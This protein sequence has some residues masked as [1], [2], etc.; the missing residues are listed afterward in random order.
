MPGFVQDLRFS[1][2]Q[3]I[4]A[5]GFTLAAVGMLALGIGATSAIFSLVEGV[6]LRPLP[7]AD[8]GRLA[9][10]GDHVGNSPGMSVTAREIATYAHASGAFASMGGFRTATYEL[11]GSERAEE[12][13][14][15]RVT[16]SAFSTLGVAPMLGR[17]FTAEEEDANHPLAV[18]SYALWLN[19]Y[20]RDPNVV[21]QTIELDRKTYS[22]IGVMPRGFE[23]PLAEGR[24]GQAQLWVPM[25]PTPEE[26]SEKEAGDWG[27]H[28][29]ARL[30]PGVAIAQAVQDAD[31][32]SQQIMRGFP[33]TMAAIHI[34]GDVKDMREDAVEDAR[35][36]LDTLLVA[37]GI[38]LLIACANVAVLMLV[39]AVRRNREFAVRLA[40][41]ARA[42]AIL[43]QSLIEG[44]LLSLAGGVAGLAMA[45][46]A[47]RIAVR[48]LPETM[49]RID[50]IRMDST[51]AV[52]AVMLALITGAVCSVA[53]AFAALRTNLLEGLKENTRAGGASSHAWIRSSLVVAEIA[54]ALVLITVSGSL[55]RSYQ[56]MLAVDPGFRPDHV[57]V[58][59]YRLPLE[60]YSTDILANTF[61]RSVLD[62]LKSAPGI[63]AAGI[64]SVLPTSGGYGMA[65]YTIEGHEAGWKLQFAPFVA[66]YGDYFHAMGIDLREGRYFTANDRAA[67]PLVAIV[68]ESMARHSWPGESPVGKRMHVG[69]PRKGLPWA[70]VIGVVAD[71]KLGSLED[72]SRD[73]W[74]YP[75]EQPAVL[76]GSD[77]AGQLTSAAGGNIALR[78]A[79]DPEQ[80]VATLRAAVAA[81]DPR[82]ALTDVQTMDEA[83]SS[84]EEPR[85]FNTGLIGGFALGA[86][87]L[88]VMGIYA[89]VAF[90]VSLRAQEIAIRMALGARRER[91]ARLVLVSGGKLALLG[92]ALGVLGSIAVSR[93]VEAFLFDVSPTDPLIYA[94]SAGVMVAMALLASA[95]PAI[96]AASTDPAEALRSI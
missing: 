68:N 55:L 8:P 52:F 64:A 90:S 56:K 9:L 75:L 49:P 65:A 70:T 96:R 3:L 30:K 51:V 29:V 31:R 7:F 42:R 67:A 89:V 12:I 34:R 92:C 46:A 32:V 86:L 35:P 15:A 80:T 22:I 19:R 40:L 26:L 27:F 54:I 77:S 57:V 66:T 78:S 50:S 2:R 38:V 72:P 76:Y 85:R 94:V 23:F 61:N 83:I 43:R 95:L 48:F 17:T 21:G 16:A 5:P 79:L 47:I 36:L 1:I 63:S 62:R 82:L 88:A 87:L 93:L 60:Q 73:Q 59:S 11:S 4:K 28:I 45:C 91:I 24:L 84:T 37:V 39:R 81:V 33:A 71:T 53:P 58:G 18:V 20:H 6:L 74:Y 69:N 25:S 14:G 44:V 10:V 41:G 13:D